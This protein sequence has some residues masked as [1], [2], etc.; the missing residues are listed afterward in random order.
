MTIAFVEF[1]KPYMMPAGG[2]AGPGEQ[3]GFDPATA[4]SLIAQ[5]VAVSSSAPSAP[6][7]P[8]VTRVKIIGTVTVGAVIYNNQEIATFLAPISAG[9]IAAGQAVSN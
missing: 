9:L 1:T 6:T 4:A 3:F 8:A 2:I 7:P 5:G